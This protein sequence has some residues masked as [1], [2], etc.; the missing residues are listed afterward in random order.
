MFIRSQLSVYSTPSMNIHAPQAGHIANYSH[1]GK[2]KILYVSPLLPMVC[3]VS[4]TGWCAPSPC[5][6][7]DKST[8]HS[9]FFPLTTSTDGTTWISANTGVCVCL[10][11]CVRVCC[12]YACV[13]R[14]IPS[15]YFQS[16]NGNGK[17]GRTTFWR[18]PTLFSLFHSNCPLN[19]SS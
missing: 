11:A 19:C 8:C 5:V 7:W 16:W 1:T 2:V 10:H 6:Q 12:I 17:G 18:G 3:V 14:L 13:H 4:P 9:A 15:P